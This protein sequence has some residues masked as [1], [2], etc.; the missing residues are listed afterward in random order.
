MEATDNRKVAIV[1]PGQGS[2]FVGMAKEFL[3]ASSTARHLMDSAEAGTGLPLRQ[4]IL[5]GP[6][7]G[8]TK[9]VHLQPALTAV[10]LICW[11]SLSEAGVTP[12][13]FAG[14]SLGEYSALCAAGS[15]T[16]E[17]V[18]RLVAERGRLMQREAEKHQGGMQAII[19]L[20]IE[21]VEAVLAGRKGGGQ[22]AIANHNAPTQIVISG[23][24]AALNEAGD[25]LSQKGAKVIPLAVS[26]AMHSPLLQDAVPDFA[27]FMETIAFA[28]PAVPVV[29]NVT[30]EEETNPEKIRAIMARQVASRVRWVD[31]INF[32]KERGVRVFIEV[33]PKKVL[34]GLLRKILPKDYEHSSFQVENPETLEK[35]LKG[36]G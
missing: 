9:T 32:L 23:E 1:F 22:V 6:L 27:A 14:H 36:L 20:T 3:E 24:P 12:S 2:Q 18:L 7:E 5:D 30:A 19:G 11:Q 13:F 4:F 33:G 28:A 10:N 21:E 26:G 35:C 25:L 34:S 8:L 31:C 15:L 16:A 17:D 29:F